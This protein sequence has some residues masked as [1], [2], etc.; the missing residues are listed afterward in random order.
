MAC[1]KPWELLAVTFGALYVSLQLFQA[2]IASLT[3]LR[4]MMGSRAADEASS[5]PGGEGNRYGAEYTAVGHRLAD[6]DVAPAFFVSSSSTESPA[7]RA[8]D[9][10]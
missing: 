9:V 3:G 5:Q 1:G 6:R 7:A 8:A 4:R 2:G 10:S